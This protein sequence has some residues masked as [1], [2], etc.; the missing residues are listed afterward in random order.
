[1][2]EYKKYDYLY[3]YLQ[4]VLYF[5]RLVPLGRTHQKNQLPTT[6]LVFA[7]PEYS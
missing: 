6:Y 7:L 1:M 3:L 5:A 2:L 4:I